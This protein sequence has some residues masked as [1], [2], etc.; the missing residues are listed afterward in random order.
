MGQIVNYKSRTKNDFEKKVWTS[1]NRSDGL[2]ISL[3]E[4]TTVFRLTNWTNVDY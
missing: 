4:P 2:Q 3:G 1:R